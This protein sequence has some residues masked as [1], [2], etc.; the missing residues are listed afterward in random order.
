MDGYRFRQ[1]HGFGPYILNFYCPTLRMCV[2]L[3]GSVHDSVEARQKDEERT[4]FLNQNRISVLRFKND[5]VRMM[6]KE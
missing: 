5:E 4:V 1:Q 2:E 3:D 6:W